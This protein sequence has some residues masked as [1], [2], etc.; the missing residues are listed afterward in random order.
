MRT[1]SVSLSISEAAALEGLAARH[2]GVSLHLLHLAALRI[3]VGTAQEDRDVVAAELL[4]IQDERRARRQVARD[5]QEDE[6]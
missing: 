3:G 2:P 1:H 6:Q 5:S 4:L